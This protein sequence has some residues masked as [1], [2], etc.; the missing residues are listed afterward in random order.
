VHIELHERSIAN[1]PETVDLARL[2]DQN[3]ARTRFEFLAVHR[4]ETASFPHELDF[5]V[6]MAMRTRTTAGER[7]KQ[8][9]GDIDVAIVSTHEMVRAAAQR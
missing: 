1:A 2:D 3:V 5:I 6:R 4:P 8:E 9:Y 7:M